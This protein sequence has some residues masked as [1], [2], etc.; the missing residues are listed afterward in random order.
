VGPQIKSVVVVSRKD[1]VQWLTEPWS[2]DGPY[3]PVRRRNLAPWKIV[4]LAG[5]VDLSSDQQCVWHIQR[6][7]SRPSTHSKSCLGTK[8]MS[9]HQQPSVH[10]LSIP[11]PLPTDRQSTTAARKSGCPV[12]FNPLFISSQCTEYSHC[13]GVWGRMAK[14]KHVCLPRTQPSA[15]SI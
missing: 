9:D 15:L 8:A 2:S 13:Q 5:L 14:R 1:Y 4:R 6:S 10:G 7:P 12:L 3:H 11:P